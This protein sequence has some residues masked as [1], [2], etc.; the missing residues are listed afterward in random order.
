MVERQRRLSGAAAVPGGSLLT[1]AHFPRGFPVWQRDPELQGLRIGSLPSFIGPVFT[2][3]N[4]SSCR[5][6]YDEVQLARVSAAAPPAV[7]RHALAR[8]QGFGM[9]TMAATWEDCVVRY[10]IYRPEVFTVRASVFAG[11]TQY[12]PTLQ[13]PLATNARSNARPCTC[14]TTSRAQ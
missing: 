10:R 8:R 12:S 4:A 3:S 13:L 11:S 1:S 2:F 7:D 6:N 9:L 14:P 5:A